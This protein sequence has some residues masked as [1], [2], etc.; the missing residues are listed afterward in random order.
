MTHSASSSA[1]SAA[2]V[3]HE[4]PEGPRGAQ[5]GAGEARRRAARRAG[6]TPRAAE[7][8]DAA[9]RGGRWHGPARAA[10]PARLGGGARGLSV[11]RTRARGVDLRPVDSLGA[12]A[13]RARNPTGAP[14]HTAARAARAAPGPLALDRLRRGGREPL[15]RLAIRGVESRGESDHGRNTVRRLQRLARQVPV[16]RRGAVPE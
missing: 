1:T 8:R 4:P 10:S 7:S 13:R 15:R 11:P 2:L 9:A 14:A 3:A 12:R 6:V 16:N 5:A